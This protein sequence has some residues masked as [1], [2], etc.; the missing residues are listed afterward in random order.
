[1]RPALKIATML[2][3]CWLVTGESVRV[4]D[5][6]TFVADLWIFPRLTT[7]ETIRVDGV[8]TWEKRQPGGSAATAFTKKWLSEGPFQ[9][10][11]CG[12]YSFNRIVGRVY[13]EGSD[14]ASQLQKNGHAKEK[15]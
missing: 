3:L 9:F 10:Y 13:R 6:D 7:R 5:G 1:M 11:T 2:Y 8:D 14:L 15:K 4:K 12:K